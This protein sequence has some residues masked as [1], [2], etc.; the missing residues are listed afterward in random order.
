MPAIRAGGLS[1]ARYQLA[2]GLSLLIA[3]EVTSPGAK[4]DLR[5]RVSG[6]LTNTLCLEQQPKNSISSKTSSTWWAQLSLEA[7]KGD[8][9]FAP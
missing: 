5:F 6:I 2:L 3:Q 9:F 7:Q 8:P 1:L 4:E